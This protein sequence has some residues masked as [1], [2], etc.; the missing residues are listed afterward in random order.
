MMPDIS[1][2]EVQTLTAHQNKVNSHNSSH[3]LTEADD[4]NEE[5]YG[6]LII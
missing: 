4:L 2:F 3:S 5:L 6:V 1:G